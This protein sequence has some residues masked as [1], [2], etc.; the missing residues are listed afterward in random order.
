MPLVPPFVPVELLLKGFKLLSLPPRYDQVEPAPAYEFLLQSVLNWERTPARLGVPELLP[1]HA[2]EQ[3][4][5][6]MTVKAPP[7]VHATGPAT[8]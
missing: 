7:F 5:A 2:P 8:S 6:P 3:A 4:S 1:V